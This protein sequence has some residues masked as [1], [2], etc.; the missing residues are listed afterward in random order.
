MATDD[1]TKS[2]IK[3]PCAESTVTFITASPDHP[4]ARAS[5]TRYS[6]TIDCPSCQ[7]QFTTH[8]DSYND[9]PIIVHKAEVDTKHAIRRKIQTLDEEIKKSDQAIKLRERIIDAIDEETS[10]AGRLRKLT[11]LH[12]TRDSYSTYR[13]RP[14]GGEQ[15]LQ[16]SSGATLARI[17]STALLGEEDHS[18][19]SAAITAIE[20]LEEAERKI[21]LKE[22]TL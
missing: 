15:A 3:C 1:V 6:A 14:Y 20:Q 21:Q 11:Q 12:L 10:L 7:T 8:Q 2:S 4:W 17:G 9:R 18:Y 5:Q 13:K 19:F 16:S 22:V